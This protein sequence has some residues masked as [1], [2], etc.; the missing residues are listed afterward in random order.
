MCRLLWRIYLLSLL[1]GGYFGR[2]MIN[3]FGITIEAPSGNDGQY[4]DHLLTTVAKKDNERQLLKR[5][6]LTNSRLEEIT[7]SAQESASQHSDIDH[8]KPQA[9]EFYLSQLKQT[10]L[11]EQAVL[12]LI[13]RDHL[14]RS[15]PYAA[16]I[17]AG[18]SPELPNYYPSDHKKAEI[19][20]VGAL[21]SAIS[22]PECRQYLARHLVKSRIQEI[23]KNMF[24]AINRGLN[25]EQVTTFVSIIYQLEKIQAAP[26]LGNLREVLL[27]AILSSSPVELVHI[28]SI[29]FTYPGGSNLRVIEDTAPVEQ[30]TVDQGHRLYPSEEV[31]F[32][33][34]NA[35][36]S[37]FRTHGLSVNTSIIVSDHDLQYC[38][39]SQQGI[40]PSSD[41][42]L[43]HQSVNRYIS[44]LRQHHPECQNIYTLTEYLQLS[45][46]VDRYDQLFSM[47]VF[48]GH[49]GGG[50]HVS[51]KILEMRVNS[52]FEHY[53]DMFG[54]GYTRELAR[55]TAI[56][57]IANVLAL[58]AVFE[59]FPTIPILVIDSRGFEDQLIGGYNPKS[60]A[61]FFT[62]LK[63]PVVK[64]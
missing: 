17:L 33:R 13:S 43:A 57:Q 35:V 30:L 15:A 9:I 53:R 20:V 4:F 64:C 24:F 44:Y 62:K 29:R 6:L 3:L 38:F 26:T 55:F 28:K 7:A 58:S 32:S 14:F 39:P 51:E 36:A 46:A 47:L 59:T 27:N 1:T 61:K 50:Q 5:F 21:I 31:I 40:V 25:P 63:D 23:A 56:R 45:H 11:Y 22:L 8:L 41:V 16:Q 37:I 34:L 12:R 42:S 49:G 10:G 60:V 2:P 54:P 52:Q 18:K 19:L 48:Q